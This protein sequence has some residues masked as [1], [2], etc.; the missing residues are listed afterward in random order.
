MTVIPKTPGRPRSQVVSPVNLLL[1]AYLFSP[2]FSGDGRWAIFDPHSKRSFLLSGKEH[3]PRLLDLLLK[4]NRGTADRSSWSILSAVAPLLRRVSEAK[5]LREISRASSDYLSKY[6]L[7]VFDYDFFDYSDQGW[8]ERDAHLMLA[9]GKSEKPPDNFASR[10]GRVHRLSGAGSQCPEE[11]NSL[12]AAVAK[13]LRLSLCAIGEIPGHPY[14][15]W[16]RR[17]SP[18]GGAR[19]PTEAVLLLPVGRIGL[20][21]GAYYFDGRTE[22]LI[23][24]RDG[25]YDESLDALSRDEIGVLLTSRVERAMWRYREPRALR[26]V[27]IDAGHIA[28]TMALV[29]GEMGYPCAVESSVN[30]SDQGFSWLTDLPLALIRIPSPQAHR[31][32]VVRPRRVNVVPEKCTSHSLLLNPT[33]YLSIEGDKL[34]LRTLWPRQVVRT[35]TRQE[36]LLLTHCIF[37]RRGDRNTKREALVRTFSGASEARLQGLLDDHI[38]QP[39]DLVKAFLKNSAPW[40]D[41]GWYLSMLAYLAEAT[42]GDGDMK[43][44]V[45]LPL[46]TFSLP[47]CESEELEKVLI[48]RRTARHFTDVPIGP[49]HVEEIEKALLQ[50]GQCCSGNVPQIFFNVQRVQGVVPKLYELRL[51]D[52]KRVRRQRAIATRE[53]RRLTI[54]QAPAGAGALS[55]WLVAD[56]LPLDLRRSYFAQLLALGAWGQLV[57]LKVTQLHLGVFLTPAVRDSELLSCLGVANPEQ[58]AVYFFC[59]GFAR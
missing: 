17:T 12:K 40:I 13:A 6:Q 5:R 29:L 45:A 11:D 9:Y 32:K 7:A 46:R 44:G 53:V 27:V 26:P 15:P 31:S 30:A 3:F 22:A 42:S 18:S 36:F 50:F 25:R 48:A 35:V 4:A 47:T 59:V 23:A 57:C 38:L 1:Q 54:G 8:R 39:A 28:L 55:I 14:G 52:G 33:A 37:S 19:H 2:S 24:V 43:A 20:G 56:L 58:K 41:K 34:V 51:S 21:R 49:Q 10:K 16:L